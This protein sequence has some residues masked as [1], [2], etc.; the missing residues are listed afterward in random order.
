MTKPLYEYKDTLKKALVQTYLMQQGKLLYEY[1]DTLKRSFVQRY[2]VQR[3]SSCI[4]AVVQQSIDSYLCFP[5]FAV[6]LCCE[7]LIRDLMPL[8]CTEVT[9]VVITAQKAENESGSGSKTVIRLHMW[10]LSCVG[11]R[12]YLVYLFISINASKKKCYRCVFISMHAKRMYIYNNPKQVP[13][14]NSYRY[15]N[16]NLF[17][18]YFWS[19]EPS[20]FC[21]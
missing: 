20:F 15:L 7:D 16:R 12:V 19:F 1:K 4:Y 8:G 2:L 14:Y 13:M 18:W 3:V 11:I 17:S 21:E 9:L 10:P 6:D 5:S